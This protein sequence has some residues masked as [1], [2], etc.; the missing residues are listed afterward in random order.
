[1]NE[2]QAKVHAA[3]SNFTFTPGFEFAGRMLEQ[4]IEQDEIYTILKELEAEGL[5]ELANGRGWRAI[6]G[7]HTV[8]TEP[9]KSLYHDWQ[10]AVSERLTILGFPEW[11]NQR[12]TNAGMYDEESDD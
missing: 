8:V 7:P 11:V 3:L 5:A 2:K 9:Y 4:G 12:A 1:M 10:V 6:P